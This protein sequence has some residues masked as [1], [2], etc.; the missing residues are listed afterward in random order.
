MDVDDDD[1]FP[2]PEQYQVPKDPIK[3]K[4]RIRRYERSLEE[5]KRLQGRYGDGYGKRFLLGPFYMIMGDL[6]GALSSFAWFEKEFPDSSDM[7]PQLLCW[8]LALKQIG[9]DDKARQMLRRTMF[10][11][12]YII[13]RL[14]GMKETRHDIWHGCNTS[15]PSFLS[16]V[17]EE[18]WELWS[19]ANRGWAAALWQSSEFQAARRRY[20]ELG[21]ELKT[22]PRG[23]ERTRVVT[24]MRRV[25]N[26]T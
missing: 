10:A 11:N 25:T 14:L 16:W 7:A 1:I 4:Q 26:D 15:E 20:I 24:E 18:Y 6:D 19:D 21:S 17:P 22:L 3:I 2:H 9:E 13:P 12:L 23:T 5:E 8:T